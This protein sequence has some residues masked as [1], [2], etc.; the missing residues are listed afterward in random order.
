MAMKRRT[1]EEQASLWIAHNKLAR[2]P[3]HPFYEALNQILDA[4]GFDR[5]A[6]DLCEPFYKEGG[7]PSI[8]PGTYFRML[9]VGYFEGIESERGIDWR[10]SD[11]LSL[12][13]FL[14]L[15]DH[16]PSPDHSSL[17]RIR[18]RLPL[19]VQVEIFRFVLKVLAR[20]DLLSGKSVGVDGSTLEAN[21]AMRSTV[22]K[23]TG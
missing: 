9:F 14:C 20:N 18:A 22:R 4:H 19:E 11:S 17:S 21:A 6:E 8:M 12:R 2:S 16:E 7:R 10:C 5:F 3:G 13:K 23:D 15:G 1:T